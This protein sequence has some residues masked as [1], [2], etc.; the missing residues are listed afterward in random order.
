MSI[1][2]FFALF[3]PYLNATAA[4]G[5]CSEGPIVFALQFFLRGLTIPV[6]SILEMTMTGFYDESVVTA[7]RDTQLALNRLGEQL[8]PDGNFGPET[9][10]AIVRHW[11][12]ND[13]ADCSHMNWWVDDAGNMRPWPIPQELS[14]ANDRT[15]GH[16]GDGECSG[17]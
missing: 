9:R 3:P 14:A 17:A 8:D 5:R 15:S 1:R 13:D 2:P 7:V 11:G 4:D 16:G 10:E 6:P 12:Q